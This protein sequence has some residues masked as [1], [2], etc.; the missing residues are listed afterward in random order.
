MGIDEFV[1][2]RENFIEGEECYI[3]SFTE[4]YRPDMG[5]ITITNLSLIEVCQLNYSKGIIHLKELGAWA[6]KEG[7]VIYKREKKYIT[8]EITDWSLDSIR[9]AY[10]PE[11][12]IIQK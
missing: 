5:I 10:K 1:M 4:I 8:N 2:N 6:I 3:V 7:E 9:R 11:I 12:A